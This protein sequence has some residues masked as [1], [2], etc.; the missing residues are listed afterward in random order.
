MR[1]SRIGRQGGAIAATGLAVTAL[2]LS[3]CII[4]TDIGGTK[5]ARSRTEISS[6]HLDEVVAANNRVRLGQH[7]DE[8]LSRYPAEILTLK[9]SSKI[10]G[11]VVEEWRADAVSRDGDLYFRRYL[12]FVDD[13]LVELSDDR[14]DYHEDY[15]TTSRWLGH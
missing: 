1:A 13:V 10:E 7:K 12:Y 2:G 8:V 3:G 9:S 14:I 11:A 6:A 15:D 4:S 5:Y